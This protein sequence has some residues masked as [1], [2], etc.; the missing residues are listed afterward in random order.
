MQVVA[1]EIA[2]I[3]VLFLQQMKNPRHQPKPGRGFSE[4]AKY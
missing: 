2:T 1:K 4:I 3:F